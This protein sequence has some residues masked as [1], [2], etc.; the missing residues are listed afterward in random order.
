LRIQSLEDLDNSLRNDAGIRV[1][2]ILGPELYQCQ[3][4]LDL[5]KRTVL[6]P[7]ALAFDFSEFCAGDG[8]AD[9]IIGA[10]NTFPMLSK[11]RLV[12]VTE[13]NNLPDSDQDALLDALP[14][15]SS[16]SLLV[17]YAE[18][19]DRRKKFYKALQDKYCVAEFPKLKGAALEKWAAS[20]VRKQGFRCSTT[21]IKK[22]VELAGSDLHMVA[23]ELEKLLLYAGEE[24][25]ISDS[26]V[27]TLIS[28]SRQQ[29][30]FELI[31]AVGRA[32]RNEAL[33]SLAN[34]L[35]MG[36]H[37]LV[38]VTMMARHCRQVLIA[39]DYLAKKANAREIAGAAQIPPFMLDQF[40]RQASATDTEKMRAMHLRLAEIDRKLKSTSADGR[41]LLE[42]L[43]CALV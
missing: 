24:K 32:D 4:A 37:P 25:N 38:V 19:F 12:L 18:D 11:K 27:E 2:L 15:I 29:S 40:L 5:V 33:R 28:G 9:Q 3:L 31:N 34:L 26:A 14:G 8:S 36:E 1:C 20:Y 23:A 22:V 16:R 13:A 35:G 6:S 21:A 7:G 43:I 41:M 39:K 10:A 42:N 17:F 30:I